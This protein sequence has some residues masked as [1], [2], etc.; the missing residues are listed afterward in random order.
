MSFSFSCIVFYLQLS[1]VKNSSKFPQDWE[2]YMYCK[3]NEEQKQRSI[4][5]NVDIPIR[6]QD[7]SN[8]FIQYLSKVIDDALA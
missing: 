5:T 8:M 3:E 2:I 4:Q 6:N 7:G 1:R